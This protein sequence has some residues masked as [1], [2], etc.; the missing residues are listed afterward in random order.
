MSRPQTYTDQIFMLDACSA[1]Q[2]SASQNFMINNFKWSPFVHT[3]SVS[4]WSKFVQ[5]LWSSMW[6]R[7]KKKLPYVDYISSKTCPGYGK[8]LVQRYKMDNVYTYGHCTHE[9]RAVTMRL[10]EPKRKCPKAV[11]TYLQHHV[12]WSG[13]LECSVKPYVARPLSKCY[14]NEF[15]FMQV[16]RH[17]KIE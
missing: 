4:P 5:Q 2:C 14:F 10:W 9:P 15:L 17:D 1:M 6:S 7:Q 11:P 3:G 8:L 16:L 13:I 12:V